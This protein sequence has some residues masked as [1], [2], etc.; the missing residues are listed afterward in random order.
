VVCS[1]A[2]RSRSLFGHIDVVISLLAVHKLSA[3]VLRA[4]RTRSQCYATSSEEYISHWFNDS[5]KPTDNNS[6]KIT[7]GQTQNNSRNIS[8]L[9]KISEVVLVLAVATAATVT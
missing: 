6:Q 2:S 1:L 4:S 9:N 7:F 8:L 5:V 3:I